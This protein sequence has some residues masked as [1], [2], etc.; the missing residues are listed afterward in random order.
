MAAKTLI[1]SALPYANGPLHLG[2][3]VEYVQTDIYVRFLR[4]CGEQVVY[5]CAD[6]THG[7]PIE[8]NAA[9]EGVTP[10]AFVQ[11]FFESHQ[12]DMRRFDIGLDY[13]GSTHFPENRHY[14]ELVYRR[15]KEA[16]QIDRREIEQTYCETDKRFLPDRFVKGTCPNCKSADQYGDVCEV[17][18]KTYA[19]TDLI[20]PRCAICGNPP[21]VRKSTHLFFKLSG[22]ADELSALLKRGD[23][24]HP[25]VSNQLHQFFEKGLSDWDIS[26]DAPY[27]GFEI[28]DEP[29]KF[30]YVWL[31]APIGY[32]STTER[33]AKRSGKAKDA[34]DFWAPEADAR[35]LHF[36]GKDIV[37]FHALFWPAVLKAARFKVPERVLVHGHLTV[38]GEKM[39]KSRGT[40]IN[41][42]TYWEKLDPTYY[43]YFIAANLG[44]GP[45]DLDLSLKDFRLRVNGELVNN[46]GN[47]ANRALTMLAGPFERRLAI[48]T[49]GPG[50]TLVQDALEKAKAVR[51]S[52]ERLDYRGAMKA[53]A[54]ISQSANQFLQAAA[55]WNT[56][57]TDRD[58]AHRDLSDAAEV[59]YLLGGLLAPVTPA[60]ATKLFEQFAAPPLTFAALTEARYPLL[61]RS[62]PIGSPSPLIGRMEEAT[63]NA[64]VGPAA[65]AEPPKQPAKVKATPPP[66]AE[67]TAPPEEIDYDG[68]A[69]VD[70]R[71]GKILSAERVPKAD[72]LLKLSVDLGEGAPRT[73]ASGIAE[74]FVPEAL[75]GK[76]VV[77][78]A[79][80]K[81]R[82]IRGIESRG[83]LLAAGDKPT[84]LSLVDPG[85]VP[86][87]TAVK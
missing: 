57:K 28:P 82:T 76:N 51:A 25:S 44:P 49:E 60:L 42:K 18:G 45:E 41:A 46:I 86:P 68:F 35:I 69:K 11:R 40:F 1:T 83:M 53:V 54:E 32:V 29:G 36:I 5:V 2:H 55:P 7:T 63:V 31:D 21:V 26:R 72:K 58:R 61:D 6:D 67:P 48:G 10:E 52:Y 33:W 77:V 75:V 37:Y 59:A 38:N 66:P 19:P 64:L 15:L 70:L 4:S 30:F 14:A 84:G 43:R 17:C 8:L 79:N 13:F 23:F 39:S 78:V 47:L 34:F 73:I 22:H 9:K 81:A 56:V 87:G 12:E 3:M 65:A 50:R 80:L 71:A 85:A 27:F 74:S 24:V 20:D 62:R 16:G